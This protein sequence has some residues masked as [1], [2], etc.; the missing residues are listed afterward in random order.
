MRCVDLVVLL[1]FAGWVGVGKALRQ[2]FR[3]AT[4]RKGTRIFCKRAF[5]SAWNQHFVFQFGIPPL[6]FFLS[7]VRA[8]GPPATNSS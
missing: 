2:C 8:L 5:R 4:R 6:L 3:H 1:W 7:F